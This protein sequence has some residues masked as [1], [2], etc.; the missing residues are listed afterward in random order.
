M[1]TYSLE[2]GKYEIDRDEN[3]LIRDMRRNGEHW[4]VGLSDLQHVKLFH[5]ALYRIDEL[6]EN[7]KQLNNRIIY[8]EGPQK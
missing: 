2:N 7:N 8:L 1:K 4:A 3:G 6:E 5:A